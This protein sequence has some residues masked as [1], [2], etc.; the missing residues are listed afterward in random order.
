[1]S[2][3]RLDDT[4]HQ[5]DNEYMCDVLKTAYNDHGLIKMWSEG[6]TLMIEYV[7]IYSY[8][9]QHSLEEL[10]NYIDRYHENNFQ[11]RVEDFP[12]SIPFVYVALGSVEK[13]LK[14]IDKYKVDNFNSRFFKA[15]CN[16]LG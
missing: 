10:T 8:E 6:F 1:M 15:H 3:E 5:L 12:D 2:L 14:H 7:L 13:T 9:F 11:N 16:N 4:L